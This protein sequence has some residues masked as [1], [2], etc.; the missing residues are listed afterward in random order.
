MGVS[1]EERSINIWTSEKK[2]TEGITSPKKKSREQYVVVILYATKEK[3]GGPEIDGIP[4][5]SL[6]TTKNQ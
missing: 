4:T 1:R 5:T 3:G 6:A 2:K